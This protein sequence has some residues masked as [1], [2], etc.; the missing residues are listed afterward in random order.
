MNLAD[1]TDGVELQQISVSS[2]EASQS[3]QEIGVPATT[4]KR[5]DSVLP[6]LGNG[7]SQKVAEGSSAAVSTGIKMVVVPRSYVLLGVKGTR[8]TLDLPHIDAHK[9]NNDRMLFKEIYVQYKAYRG[10][11]RYWLS[12]WKLS[13]CDFVKVS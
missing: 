3:S 10:F 8:Q 4:T 6:K 9:H 12:V 7:G 11:L 5:N 2:D 13:Y 1:T